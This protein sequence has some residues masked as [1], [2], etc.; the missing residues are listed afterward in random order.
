M[1]LCMIMQADQMLLVASTRVRW[2]GWAASVVTKEW[3]GL[4]C[5]GN[6][7]TTQRR[8]LGRHMGKAVTW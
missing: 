4:L 1:P 8:H 2:H 6:V 7:A 3:E 5:K